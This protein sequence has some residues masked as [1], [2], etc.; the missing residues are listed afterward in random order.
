[1]RIYLAIQARG[2]CMTPAKMKSGVKLPGR[3]SIP[4]A[5][6]NMSMPP[7]PPPDHPRASQFEK[8][9][10][11]WAGDLTAKFRSAT[12]IRSGSRAAAAQPSIA[13]PEGA[14]S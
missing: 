9:E 8:A 11:L 13:S 6:S 7:M 1:M 2:W 4:P 5:T 10:K 14:T 3:C 12:V